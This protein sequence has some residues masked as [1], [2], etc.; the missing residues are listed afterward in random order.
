MPI[1]VQVGHSQK[2]G[3]PH[4]GSVGASCNVQF[5]APQDLL[6][7]DFAQFHEEV[8]KAF[9][10]CQEAVL[11]QLA[12]EGR[13]TA[14]DGA[15]RKE[16]RDQPVA[17]ADGADARDHL[18]ESNASHPVTSAAG[19]TNAATA[20]TATRSARSAPETPGESAAADRPEAA[21]AGKGARAGRVRGAAAKSAGN[22]ARTAANGSATRPATARQLGYLRKLAAEIEGVGLRGLE[23]LAATGCGRPLAELSGG[24]ASRLIDRLQAVQQGVAPLADLFPGGDA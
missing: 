23:V 2:K 11:K 5:E 9:I 18:A 19:N 10:A 7:G 17:A 6:R 22:G 24:E 21:A 13:P 4:Y 14:V 3:L 8:H 1:T 12:G 16:A 20:A 15:R